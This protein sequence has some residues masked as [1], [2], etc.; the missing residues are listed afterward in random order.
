MEAMACLRLSLKKTKE[1]RVRI[2]GWRL[3]TCLRLSVK[4]A[5]EARVRTSR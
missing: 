1:A 4:K 3:I 2:G 5:K